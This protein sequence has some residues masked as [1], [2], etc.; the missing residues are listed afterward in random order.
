[1]NKLQYLSLSFF[2]TFSSLYCTEQPQI[3]DSNNE[4]VS[5]EE[6]TRQLNEEF[7][8]EL[9]RDEN[10]SFINENSIDYDLAQQLLEEA[11]ERIKTL[12]ARFA[13]ARRAP[14]STRRILVADKLLLV[15]PPGVG[16]S[17][18][19]K[20]IAQAIGRPFIFLQSSLLANEY[21]NSGAQNLK[22]TIQEIKESNIPYVVI[23][24]EIHCLIDKKKN[25][26]KADADTSVALW[27]LIDD[28]SNHKNILFI[29]TTN[30][31]KNIPEAL[32]NRFTNCI[33]EVGL[34]GLMQREKIINFY[35]GNTVDQNL[36]KKI[37]QQT[38]G[39]SA[40]ELKELTRE[41]VAHATLKN[42]FNV[43]YDDFQCSRRE[44]INNRNLFKQPWK[45]AITEYCKN[46]GLGL[47]SLTVSVASLMLQF[48]NMSH[49]RGI[50]WPMAA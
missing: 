23:L 50:H 39:F 47:A 24:D 31:L 20:A 37:A 27:Q 41:M 40:R 46:N 32:Q 10:N 36:L 11:P 43:S 7:Q 48:Q 35:M 6:L 26:Q 12:I 42:V 21:Q 5:I 2:I 13:R 34:P 17:D 18:L 30:S 16:K 4:Q 45:E 29:G 19:A 38:N 49:P 9:K 8:R 14:E 1:M 22:R 33:V 15:G 25:E 44:I 28:C 3:N